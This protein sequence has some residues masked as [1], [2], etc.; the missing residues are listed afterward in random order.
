MNGFRFKS[1]G[2]IFS[3]NRTTTANMEP[4]CI[5]TKKTCLNS[6]DTSS[7]TNSSSRIIWP[8][9]LMGSHS[10]IP[11]TMPNNTAFNISAI[12]PSIPVPHLSLKVP[13]TEGKS[14]A[15]HTLFP[16][17]TFTERCCFS[18]PF[19]APLSHILYIRREYGNH[20][21]YSSKSI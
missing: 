5:T 19:P 1:N 20:D 13:P 14:S 9:L 12:F 8:V 15:S 21:R 2:N 16:L 6:H 10:V 4:N 17:G 11:C 7:R 3:Q 18:V